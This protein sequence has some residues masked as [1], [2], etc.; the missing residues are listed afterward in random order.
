MPQKH[1]VRLSGPSKPQ[2]CGGKRSYGSRHEAETVKAEQEIID[3]E[4]TLSIYHCLD[5]HAWHLTRRRSDTV[6]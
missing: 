4:L 2:L 1:K 3:P 6:I 5:C